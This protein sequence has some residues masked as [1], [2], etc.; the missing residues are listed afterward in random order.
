MASY[1]RRS[2]SNVLLSASRQFPAVLVTGPRQ[3][4]KSTLLKREFPQTPYVSFDD[5]LERRF[6]EDD[7]NGFL[8]RFRDGPVILDE[9][10]EAPGLFPYLKMRIDAERE[11]AGRYLMTG[12]QQFHAMARVSESLAGRVA[13]LDLLPFHVLETRCL[14]ELTIQEH[15]WRGGYPEPAL[16]P[17][18]RDV[19]LPS[20]VR[21]Y[22]ERDV[23]SITAVQDIGLFQTFLGLVAAMHGQELNLA[24]LA[25]QCGVSQPTAKRWLAILRA[26]WI[27]HLLEPCH[28]N[29]GKRL[30]KSP[31]VYFLDPAPAAYLTRQADPASLFAGAMGGAFFEGFVVCETRKILSARNANVALSYWRSRDQVEVDL[32]IEKDGAVWPVEI[33]KT[34]TPTVQHGAGLKRFKVLHEAAGPVGKCQVVCNASERRPMPGGIDA[35]PWREFLDWVAQL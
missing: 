8:D 30:V 22:L 12:S 31:K 25:R 6:A 21:T 2:L 17:E 35:V 15:L 19:W 5:P 34:A 33:K 13:I 3:A 7:P 26:S 29:L 11:K 4:G 9:I 20:Y 14:G 23:R 10:Q 32:L 27:I 28:R 18:K 24:T 16:E 1:I